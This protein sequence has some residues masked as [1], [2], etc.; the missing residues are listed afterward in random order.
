VP[1]A[2]GLTREAVFFSRHYAY[3]GMAARCGPKEAVD[4]AD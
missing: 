4:A 2:T 1:I 3:R